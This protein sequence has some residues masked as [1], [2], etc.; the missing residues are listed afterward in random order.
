MQ[1]PGDNLGAGGC[2]MNAEF[3]GRDLDRILHVQEFR[4]HEHTMLGS[5]NNVP[6]VG[7]FSDRFIQI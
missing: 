1:Q 7:E 4:G 6:R 5:C 3:P 2:H